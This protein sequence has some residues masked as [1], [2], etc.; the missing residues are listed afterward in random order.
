MA[1]KYF[2]WIVQL[3]K[4]QVSG[5]WS[6]NCLSPFP[7]GYGWNVTTFC[8]FA[9]VEK[10]FLFDI[11]SIPAVVI[12]KEPNL[13]ELFFC[14]SEIEKNGDAQSA[15]VWRKPFVS[16]KEI[17]AETKK[18]KVGKFL[19]FSS[20]L[21]RQVLCKKMGNHMRHTSENFIWISLWWGWHI[22]WSEAQKGFQTF[23]ILDLLCSPLQHPPSSANKTYRI[24]RT[25]TNFHKKIKKSQRE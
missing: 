18:N 16:I 1:N 4:F 25:K 7:I 15:S 11:I 19:L 13:A 8:W 12:F 23:W 14:Q 6:K 5:I 24:I 3:G 10:F 17:F 22:A 2:L 20:L 21:F 9:F